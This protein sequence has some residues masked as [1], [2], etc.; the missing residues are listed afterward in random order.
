[1]IFQSLSDDTYHYEAEQFISKFLKKQIP[2][3]INVVMRS[4]VRMLTKTGAKE[5]IESK[6]QENKTAPDYYEFTWYEG[7][8]S[9]VRRG[10]IH[11]DVIDLGITCSSL[12]LVLH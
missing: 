7:R 1:M 4:L 2:N 12:Q 6:E 5:V 10:N 11:L 3:M 8:S 9:T